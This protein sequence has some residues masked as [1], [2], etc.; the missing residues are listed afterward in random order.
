MRT[1]CG[2]QPRGKENINITRHITILPPLY[3]YDTSLLFVSSSVMFMHA[4]LVCVPC[5]HLH[6]IG[7]GSPGTT[8]ARACSSHVHTFTYTCG[9]SLSLC[10]FV[11]RTGS[12][13][14]DQ[15]ESPISQSARIIYSTRRILCAAYS[16]PI[17][18]TSS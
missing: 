2:R 3:T 5:R 14:M 18:A 15:H 6:Q 7:V 9:P 16:T 1:N 12:I 13:S 17:G 8:I 4:H 11:N 10:V